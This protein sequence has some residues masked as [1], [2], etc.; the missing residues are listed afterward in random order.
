MLYTAD[1]FVL[2]LMICYRTAQSRRQRKWSK[3]TRHTRMMRKKTSPHGFLHTEVNEDNWKKQLHKHAWGE[4]VLIKQ[5][6][7]AHVCKRPA[8]SW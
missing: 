4:G 5:M 1:N 2:Q 7:H 6:H 8:R 3:G